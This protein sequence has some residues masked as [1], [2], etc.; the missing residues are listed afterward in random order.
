MSMG[1]DGCDE[2][3][4]EDRCHMTVVGAAKDFGRVVGE[5]GHD[6]SFSHCCLHR[7]GLL[8]NG[9]HGVD[10]VGDDPDIASHILRRSVVGT[11]HCAH[12]PSKNK[13]DTHHGCWHR[14]HPHAGAYESIERVVVVV[15]RSHGLAWEEVVLHLRL[16]K[17]YDVMSRHDMTHLSGTRQDERGVDDAGDETRTTMRMGDAGTEKMMSFLDAALMHT[18]C[19]LCFHL[20]PVHHCS[21]KP[22]VEG[23]G[24]LQHCSTMI[25]Q[26]LQQQLRQRKDCP[27]TVVAQLQ[28]AVQ[29]HLGGP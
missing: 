3:G 8:E 2:H 10:A 6:G 18:P 17:C 29:D 22:M 28:Q 26:L 1:R 25:S 12:V 4:R 27:V 5:V 11:D 16:A 19:C 23:C 13:G 20:P 15:V 21:P 24:Y 7:G 9:G 14:D